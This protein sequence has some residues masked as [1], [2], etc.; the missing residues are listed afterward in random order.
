[1]TTM[2]LFQAVHVGNS[3]RE[4]TSAFSAPPW[5]N[6]FLLAPVTVA[7]AIHAAA[8]Y[9]PPTQSLLRVQPLPLQA[10]LAAATSVSV[11]VAVEIHKAIVGRAIEPT[12][13]RATPTLPAAR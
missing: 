9:L 8:L 13:R 2:M 10:W 7:L 3:R 12:G 1:M 5:T 6:R 11:L 4:R